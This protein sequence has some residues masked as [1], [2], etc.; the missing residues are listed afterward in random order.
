MED[1]KLL[2]VALILASLS[3]ESLKTWIHFGLQNS[4]KSKAVSFVIPV[5]TIKFYFITGRNYG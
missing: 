2:N 5:E 3:L 4:T 1:L